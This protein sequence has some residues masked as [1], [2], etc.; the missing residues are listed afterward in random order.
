[1]LYL[2]YPI[3]WTINFLMDIAMFGFVFRKAK[4]KNEISIAEFAGETPDENSAKIEIAA[5]ETVVEEK[6]ENN[7]D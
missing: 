2:S 5:Y 7:E 1:M 4:K 6:V 3:S